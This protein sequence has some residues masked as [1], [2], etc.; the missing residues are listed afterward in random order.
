MS[1][2]SVYA[3]VKNENYN[4]TPFSV[5]KE[6]VITTSSF[7]DRGYILHNGRYQRKKTPVSSS[8]ALND[9]INTDGVYMHISY[10]SLRHM[11]YNEEGGSL[12]NIESP[13]I[14]D[15]ERN[16]HLTSSAIYFPYY[17]YGEGIQRESLTLTDLDNSI[18]LKDDGYG[19]LY[20]MSIDTSSFSS[21]DNVIIG[22]Y[23][24][25]L[26]NH[27]KD[28]KGYLI[29]GSLKYRS[30]NHTP[31]YNAEVV[32]ATLQEG[33]TINSTSF[34][35][36]LL[37][38][39]SYIHLKNNEY[40]SYDLEDNF[41]VSFWIKTE[42]SSSLESQYI[43]SKR[44]T[45]ESLKYGD[46]QDCNEKGE[47]INRRG[48]YPVV[49]DVKTNVYPLSFEYISS[50]SDLGKI[51]FRRSDG[52]TSITMITSGSVNDGSYHHIC[53]SK[54]GS[55]LSLYLD[56]NIEAS[57]SDVADQVYNYHD[58]VF[59]ALNRKRDQSLNGSLFDVKL[60]DTYLESSEV[61]AMATTSS[62]AI[63]QTSK[64]GNVF[65]KTGVVAVTSPLNKYHDIFD[66]NYQIYYK[67]TVTHYE[68]STYV[69]IDKE[70]FNYTFNPTAT[71]GGKSSRYIPE[72]IS[73]S[74]NP[75]ITT[76]GLYNHRNELVAVGKLG[77]PIRKRDDVNFNIHIKMDY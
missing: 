69:V 77:S 1:V 35:S 14:E 51:R 66:N 73:G 56:G 46:Y 45:L 6:Y 59:G 76:I 25:D 19:N 72:M 65:Y 20:D 16:L 61:S 75:Y 2:F 22:L 5:N 62:I 4:V 10:R 31:E 28:G 55:L 53:F 11:F 38:S 43:I 47:L 7:E 32:N 50:G 44:G 39:S 3:P 21:Y 15:L 26:I 30:T 13:D 27:T 36:S 67:N 74:L 70:K 18:I 64:V 41:A 23:F 34:G 57:G 58:Y 9:P 17:D 71:E 12:N 48:L 63:R 54:S 42:A 8:K 33:V 49:E 40:V 60:Y 24:D 52:S 29:S 68:I 37:L